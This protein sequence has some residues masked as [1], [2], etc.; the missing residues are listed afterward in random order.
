EKL[1]RLAMS[2][3]GTSDRSSTAYRSARRSLERYTTT[4]TEERRPGLG[5]LQQIVRIVRRPFL[6]PKQALAVQLMASVIYV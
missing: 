3:S 6:D 1:S 4:A 5:R 2:M